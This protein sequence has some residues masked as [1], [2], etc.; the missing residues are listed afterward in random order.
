MRAQLNLLAQ[1]RKAADAE[2][3][4]AGLRAI[5]YSVHK[6]LPARLLLDDVLVIWNR[7]GADHTAA[8][9]FEQ[10][11][12][13]VLVLENGYM[14]A[15]W[16]GSRWFA[17]SRNHH[18]GWGAI[19]AGGPER[20]DSWGVTLPPLRT[21]GEAIVLAQRG[22]AEP[23]QRP[24]AGYFDMVARL[25]KARIRKHPGAHPDVPPWEVDMRDCGLAITWAS[26]SAIRA[27]VEFGAQVVAGMPRWIGAGLTGKAPDRLAAMRRIAWGMWSA[28]EISGGEAFERVLA[29]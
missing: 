18:N 10:S 4:A 12:C 23:Q 1:P 11:G 26:A 22:I 17:V 6:Q 28:A 2:L 9:R 16:R 8:R 19:P 5:G 14:G 29:C 13:K 27:S 21:E 20:W 25:H 24:P 7:T 3:V 15:Q